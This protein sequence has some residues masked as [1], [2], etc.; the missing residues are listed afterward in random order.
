MP[1]IEIEGRK[2]RQSIK[3]HLEY[4]K[5]DTVVLKCVG[6]DGFDWSILEIGTEGIC[7]LCYGL[8]ECSGLK[9]GEDEFIEIERG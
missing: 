7:H 6:L 4:T 8:A 1:K 3:L 2:E 5:H 9:L